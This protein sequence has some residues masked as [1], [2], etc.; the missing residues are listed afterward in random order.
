[1]TIKDMTS[2][3]E[4]LYSVKGRHIYKRPIARIDRRGRKRITVGFTVCTASEIVD[5]EG[6]DF[7]AAALNAYEDQPE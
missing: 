6:L 7:I 4:P 3:P 2:R 5:A 1:M